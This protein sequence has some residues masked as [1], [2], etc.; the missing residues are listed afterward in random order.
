MTHP[1]LQRYA[2]FNAGVAMASAQ[3]QLAPEA[4]PFAKYCICISTNIEGMG[5]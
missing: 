1:T 5:G 4:D 2:C 3:V